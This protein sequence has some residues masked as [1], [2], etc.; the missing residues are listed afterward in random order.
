MSDKKRESGFYW[1]LEDNENEWEAA[2]YFSDTNVWNLTGSDL[3]YFDEDFLEIDER[4]IKREEDNPMLFIQK[5]L[6]VPK[7]R[8][9]FNNGVSDLTKPMGH[10]M[11]K[12]QRNF[13][14]STT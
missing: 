2:E 11:N 13:Y 6:G 8:L 9:G 7:D 10:D 14:D 3:P 12:F 1:I 5:T 4:Q